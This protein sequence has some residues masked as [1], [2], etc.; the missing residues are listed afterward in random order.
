M[1][2]ATGGMGVYPHG[3]RGRGGAQNA[4]AGSHLRVAQ[5]YFAPDRQKQMS[6]VCLSETKR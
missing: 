1:D 5:L 3:D 6:N 2:T 4:V